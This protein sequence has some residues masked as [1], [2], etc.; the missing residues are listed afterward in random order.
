MAR[1]RTGKEIETLVRLSATI[2]S[3]LDIIQ[4]LNN[5]MCFVEELMNAE[6]SS[7][8]EL[9][10]ER[11][12]LF[13]RLARGDSGDKIREIRMRIGEGIAGWVASSGE[14]LVVPDTENDRRFSKRVD[15][16]SGFKTKSIIALPIKNKGRILGVLEVLN[17][18]QPDTFHSDD[19]EVLTIVANQ[20]G[21]ALENARLFSRLQEKFAF[22]RAELEETQAKLLRSERL[23]ALGQLSQGVAHEVR[24]PVMS[25]GGFARRLRKRLP[26]DDP[27]VHYVDIILEET[28]R[29]EK[30]VKDVEQYT[31]MPRP[32]IKEVKLSALLNGVLEVWQR[33][34]SSED[35]QVEMKPLPEDPI[36]SV[37]QGLMVR[38]LIQLL[39]NAA[40]AMPQGGV[41][42][43]SA[44]WEDRWMVISVRDNGLGIACEDLPRVFDPFF[45]SKTQGPGLGLTTVHR[46]VSDHGGHVRIFSSPGVGTEARICFPPSESWALSG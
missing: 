3:S 20:I 4:V 46:I 37:D 32:E 41:I 33:E 38:A 43:V 45:T 29:L 42:S 35:I 36:V 44:W 27:A 15:S 30:M 28:A 12:E 11:N 31:S 26:P 40:D 19:L 1:G 39:R 10:H 23:A 17:K 24:N 7:I 5:S 22:T 2:N 13:F 16:L 6:A 14:P 25:I 34:Y 8:F 9:D 18:R 21:I